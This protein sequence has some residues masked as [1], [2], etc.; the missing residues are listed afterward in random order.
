MNASML[1]RNKHYNNMRLIRRIAHVRN[2]GCCI[3]IFR[4]LVN[5]HTEYTN[6]RN[7]V[8]FIITPVSDDVIQQIDCILKEYEIDERG[9]GRKDKT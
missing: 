4:L 6:Q 1:D 2:R 7:A 3:H 8:F 9:Q 5:K